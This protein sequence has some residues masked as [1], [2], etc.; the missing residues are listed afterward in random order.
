MTMSTVSQPHVVGVTG[1]V[2]SPLARK[3]QISNHMMNE[4][5]TIGCGETCPGTSGSHVTRSTPIGD[6]PT[7][8]PGPQK[9]DNRVLCAQAVAIGLKVPCPTIQDR[10]VRVQASVGLH[11]TFGMLPGSSL[12]CSY[13]LTDTDPNVRMQEP[14]QGP[15]L[16]HIDT[17]G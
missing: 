5:G 11:Q 1:P 3:Q 4:A 16:Q 6:L 17:G 7:K 14:V 13:T 9:V 2:D 8:L 15:C 12:D 10:R